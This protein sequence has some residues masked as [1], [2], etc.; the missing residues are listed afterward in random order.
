[1]H[2]FAIGQQHHPQISLLF[3]DEDPATYP[4]IRLD[5]LGDGL[6]KGFRNSFASFGVCY[7]ACATKPIIVQGR[8]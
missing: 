1:M 3:L 4:P 5:M 8:R 2:R 6:P 7:P